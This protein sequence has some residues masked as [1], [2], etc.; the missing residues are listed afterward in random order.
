MRERID[1]GGIWQVRAVREFGA[2][3]REEPWEAPGWL[4]QELPAHWQECPE[5]VHHTGP[6][7]YRRRIASVP[8][9]GRRWFLRLNG[10]FYRY[11]VY[12][13]GRLLGRHEG[14]FAPADFEVTGLLTGDDLLVLEVECP[15]EAKKLDKRLITGVFSHWDHLDPELH[16]GGVWLPVELFSTGSAKLDWLGVETQGFDT[17]SAKVKV[18]LEVDSAVAAN[19]LVVLAFVPANFPG[20]PQVFKYRAQLGPGRNRLTYLC[21]VERYRLW[22]THE[23]GEPNLY[24]VEAVLED[25]AGEPL[26]VLS[27]RTGLRTIALRNWVFYLNN[28][29]LFIKGSNCPPPEARLA[30]VTR[31][32]AAG[33]VAWAVRAHMN[34]LR[35][36]AHV[37]H[38]FLYEA[39]DEQGILL[40]Q[41]LPLQWLYAR[42][43]LPE[44]QRQAGQ[45]VRLLFNHPSVA[46]WCMHN[47]PVYMVD[48]KDESFGR[49]L[50]TN[51]SVF[52]YSWN[53]DVMDR[54]LARAARREDATRPV[55][56]ASGE[57]ALLHPGGDT[58]WYFGW[59]KTHGPLRLFDLVCRYAP[60]NIRFVSEFGAQSLPNRESALRFMASGPGRPDWDTLSR[61][62]SAQPDIMRFWLDIDACPD[63]DTLVALTQ[64]YQARLNQYY[65]DRLR[66]HK[67][68]PTG[69]MLAFSF[70]DPNPAVSWSVLDYWRVPKSSYH[71]LQRCYHPEYVFA[72]FSRESY[73]P[74]ETVRVPVYLTSDAVK[75]YARVE[76]RAAVIDPAGEEVA[77]GRFDSRLAADART[78]P[79]GEVR[80]VPAATGQYRVSLE[81]VYDAQ[82][83]RNEYEVF[84]TEKPP[85]RWG[86]WV[87]RRK[88]PG[89]EE[90]AGR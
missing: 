20:E 66:L 46:L 48:T 29:R 2:E 68:R 10:V 51:W 89:A 61:R 62:H 25:R 53:R 76:V 84:V 41:D 43:A 18:S 16:P 28:E 50:R 19:P 65:I 1:L 81:L 78:F 70:A 23:L 45:M 47:E 71:L 86:P 75:S 37:D 83:F 44:A 63:L 35:V 36:H 27:V 17:R 69:G 79:V 58:H 49:A 11:A 39:A 6:V 34:M 72:L 77:G 60:R 88:N 30:R 13:N 85:A 42:E 26:D 54:Q 64:W 55:L 7:V 80:F 90:P 57:I 74:G 31:E 33:D 3:I 9:A 67:Y 12:L 87:L 8:S 4:I 32:R 22:W 24:Q 14:Y 21:E 5:L 82:T 15:P 59:Y 38:P 56:R 73:R 40:W 52:V